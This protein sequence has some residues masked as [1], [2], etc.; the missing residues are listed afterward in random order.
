M[1]KLTVDPSP[2]YAT[3]EVFY[4]YNNNTNS[5]YAI[6]PKYPSNKKLVLK[7]LPWNG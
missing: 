6:F 2:G 3:K 4:T 5:L 7:D 1:M